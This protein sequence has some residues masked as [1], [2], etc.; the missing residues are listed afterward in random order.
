MYLMKRRRAVALGALLLIG[1]TWSASS[2]S[3]AGSGAPAAFL[4]VGDQR[5]RGESAWFSRG[6]HH[7]NGE[8]S[9]LHGDGPAGWPAA[10]RNAPNERL[11]LKFPKDARPDIVRLWDFRQVTPDGA[12]L[13]ESEEVPFRLRPR[14][15]DGEIVG[16]RV[17]FKRQEL[18]HHYLRAYVRWNGRHNCN[19][20]EAPY[21]FHSETVPGELTAG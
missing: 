7:A 9:V 21:N 16:W 10:L 14:R 2:P 11:Q 4:Q 18:G 19:F 6:R 20:H 3:S 17:N 15:I 1:A 5:Q 13:G 8:C 12:P